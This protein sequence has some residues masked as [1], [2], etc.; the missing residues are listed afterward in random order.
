MA[1]ERCWVMALNVSLVGFC[2]V[3]LLRCH[4]VRQTPESCLASNCDHPWNFCDDEIS[5]EKEG[6]RLA[7]ECS[8][9]W[10]NRK[11][12]RRVQQILP[13]H[14][15]YRV[16]PV[17]SSSCT[18]CAWTDSWCR[19][20]FIALLKCLLYSHPTNCFARVSLSMRLAEAREL[21]MM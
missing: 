1:R 14:F 16:A 4:H 8:G 17:P 2:T 19:G 11:V 5:V 20:G 15:M 3:Q 9:G 7:W 10:E 13:Q 21:S 12:S 6:W 18:K